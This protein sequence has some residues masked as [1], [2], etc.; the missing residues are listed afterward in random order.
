MA[1]RL[2]VGSVLVDGRLRP[3]DLA[4]ADGRV[5]EVLDRPGDPGLVAVP[6]LI[7][8][9]VNGAHGVDVL[10]ADT[11][12]LA[13]LER[14]LLAG[15]VTAWQPTLITAP[16]EV[17][18]GAIARLE[19]LAGESRADRPHLVGIHLEGPFLSPERI[20]VHPPQHRLEPDP[21]LAARL[22]ASS[23]VRCMTLAPE[24]PG[25]LDLVRDLCARG[26]LVSIGHSDADAVTADAAFD[27]GARTVTHLGNAMRPLTAREPGVLGAA[28][29]R[30]DVVVQLIADGHHL[31]PQTIRMAVRAAAGR[32]VLV[33]D[34][35]AAAGLGDG[36][37]S[38]GGTPVEVID[39]AVRRAD[40]TLAGS[41]L[42]ML[43]AV[44]HAVSIGIDLDDALTAASS[45]PARLLGRDDLGRIAPGALAD[46]IVL[47]RDLELQ[48]VLR[49]G[50]DVALAPAGR[51]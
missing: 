20:G 47:D 17:T 1:T 10:T 3:G 18:L 42:T 9:Q 27:A 8:L 30:D 2:G 31:A 19:A 22:T 48:R 34:A 45:T 4:I 51:P 35:V 29:A 25:A 16:P 38:L 6:G 32:W 24:R 26:I 12:A 33:T 49:G 11:A 5:V 21:G 40:G 28:L 23:L 37:S 15:G 50:Q 46:V 7:D 41:A 44:R 13:R 39:G 43:E 14:T 36:A